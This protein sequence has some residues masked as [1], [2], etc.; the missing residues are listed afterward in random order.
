MQG[1]VG[2]SLLHR[3]GRCVYFEE[4]NDIVIT[5]PEWLTLHI[6]GPLL[7]PRD[8]IGNQGTVSERD[9]LMCWEHSGAPI[10]VLVQLFPMLEKYGVCN[11]VTPMPSHTHTEGMF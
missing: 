9:L 1:R 4:L 5:D 7:Q 2:L 10:N 6:I 11:H 3:W 8:D